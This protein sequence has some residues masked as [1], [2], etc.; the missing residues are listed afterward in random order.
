MDGSSLP[1]CSRVL[2]QKIRRTFLICSI[3]NNATASTA[4]ELNPEDFGWKLENG[5]YRICW[6]YGDASPKI[7][8]IISDIDE[9][10]SDDSDFENDIDF[11]SESDIDEE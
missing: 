4:P 7:V 1:P 10:K 11:D 2:L 6:Y 3:W 9:E 8:D 5:F